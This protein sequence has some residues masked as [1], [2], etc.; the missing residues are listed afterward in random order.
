M[1]YQAY[2]Q[3]KRLHNKHGAQEFGRICQALLEISLFKE[4]RYD[5]RGR[6]VERPDIQMKRANV[7]YNVEV[8]AQKRSK[9]SITQRDLN[10]VLDPTDEDTLPI[11]AV[12][13]FGPNPRWLMLDARHIRP[14]THR[15]LG[16]QIHLIE[17]LSE[18]VNSAFPGVLER[19]FETAF[20]G[21]S[22]SIRSAFL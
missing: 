15:K 8:K 18:D 9:F 12:L 20:K 11:I 22:A 10:G 2:K 16:V 7:K 6:E 13:D 21:G 19:C 4:L 3:L 1:G 14:G 5:G 17:D